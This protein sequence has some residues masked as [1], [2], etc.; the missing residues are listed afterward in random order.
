MKRLA[1]D[2][3]IWAVQ[4]ATI[5]DEKSSDIKVNSGEL[6]VLEG[7]LRRILKMIYFGI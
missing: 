7:F 1:V 3:S 4:F 6:R 5:F 2:A